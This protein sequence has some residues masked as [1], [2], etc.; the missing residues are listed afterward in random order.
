RCPCPCSKRRC[1]RCGRELRV[2]RQEND[3]LRLPRRHLTRTIFTERRRTAHGDERPRLMSS[4]RQGFF[5]GAGLGL[6]FLKDRRAAANLGVNLSCHRGTPA[7]DQTRQRYAHKTGNRKNGRVRKQVAQERFN[8]F[9]RIR[10]AEIEQDNR[11]LH[12]AA[13]IRATSS[14]TWSVGVGGRTPWPRLKIKGLPR[15]VSRIRSVAEIKALPPLI[16]ATGSRLPCTGWRSAN[17]LAQ[18]IGTVVSSEIA[19]TPVSLA[20]RS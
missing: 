15:I 13:L 5:N 12:L 20:Y 4:Y 2:E 8:G 16:S 6:G 3:L 14:P 9:R 1:R 19:V 17:C 18:P 10:P 11:Q 7:R